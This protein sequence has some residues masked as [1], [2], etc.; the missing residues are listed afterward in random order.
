MIALLSPI[1][2]CLL[3]VFPVFPSF[4]LQRMSL[5][6][7]EMVRYT[8]LFFLFPF[9]S[10]QCVC[11]QNV[12]CKRKTKNR[13]MS[14][15]VEKNLMESRVGYAGSYAATTAAAGVSPW[16]SDGAV[17]KLSGCLWQQQQDA[18]F[19]GKCPLCSC[20]SS[21]NLRP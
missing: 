2:F 21:N 16:N 4:L 10:P 6:P 19:S 13:S 11:V 18:G 9:F 14:S 1:T 3:I 20:F 17:R 8:H 15:S 5:A 12:H 7:Q